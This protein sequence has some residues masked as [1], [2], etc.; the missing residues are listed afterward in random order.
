MALT[1]SA[2]L[3]RYWERPRADDWVDVL[4]TFPLFA[5]V[6]RRRL[7]RLVRQA[8]LIE[9]A[10]GERVLTKG[11]STDSLY[12]VLSG[13]ATAVGTPAPRRLHTGDY[14][15]ELALVDGAPRSATVVATEELD[16]MALAARTVLRGAGWPPAGPL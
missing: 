7:R 16:G 15:G 6:G 8:K 5:H 2:G 13:T 9:L 14:F 11:E 4:A 12:V 1:R 10:P 3:M